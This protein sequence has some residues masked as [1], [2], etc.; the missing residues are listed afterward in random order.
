MK[1]FNEFLVSSKLCLSRLQAD[2]AELVNAEIYLSLTTNYS[3]TF[4]HPSSNVHISANLHA[5]CTPKV[6]LHSPVMLDTVLFT[7]PYIR[8]A[9]QHGFWILSVFLKTFDRICQ[10]T[11]YIN[12]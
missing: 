1:D 12:Y 3:C 5:I 4:L 9:Y 11:E 2:P 10:Y 6:V 8:S 7:V